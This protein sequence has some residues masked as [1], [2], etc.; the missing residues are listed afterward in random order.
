MPRSKIGSLSKFAQ[1][2]IEK[3]FDLLVKAHYHDYPLRGEDG[4][5]IGREFITTRG[6][7]VTRI[8]EDQHTTEQE[9]RKLT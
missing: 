4:K 7:K 2:V 1:R 5:I 9:D 3:F 6:G 8:K